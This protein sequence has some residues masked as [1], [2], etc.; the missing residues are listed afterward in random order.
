VRNR[1]IVFFL[2]IVFFQIG[3]TKSV[4]LPDTKLDRE[5]SPVKTEDK[6]ILKQEITKDYKNIKLEIVKTR[7]LEERAGPYNSYNP[8]FSSDESYIAVE[9]NLGTFN[10]IYIYNLEGEY[11]DEKFDV[12]VKKVNEIYLEEESGEN[13]LETL[14]TDTFHESFNYEFNWFPSGNAF[15]FT[16]NAGMGEYNLFI[17]SV[18]PQDKSI[19]DIKKNIGPNTFRNY[20]MMTDEVEKDGQAK[21]SPDG[22]KVVFTSGRTGNGD[23]Y[24]LDLTSGALKR[25]TNSE[26]TDFFPQWSPDSRDIVYTTGGKQA[27]DIHIIRN[28]GNDNE[29]QEV[30]IHWFFD[31]VLPTFS[32]DGKKISFY[33]TYNLERDPFNTKRWG[34]MIIPSD[35]TAPRAGEELIEYFHIPDIVKDNTQN[36]A[37]FPDNTHILY[38]KNIDSDYNPIYIYNIENREEKFIETGTDINHDITVSPHG[39][40]SFRAQVLGWDRIFIAFSTY[41]LEYTKEVSNN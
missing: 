27:H 35:G 9:V 28:A 29:R 17:G 23:L 39:L 24:L 1:E 36:T 15:I 2:L 5:P 21:V 14:L 3:C 38:A 19:K 25:L 31:D 11:R 26:D 16:S 30:L 10:K 33:T 6:N 22:T 18:E 32:P 13:S 7:R 4:K 40:V 12:S 20:F 41:F 8:Q 34:L 37:W